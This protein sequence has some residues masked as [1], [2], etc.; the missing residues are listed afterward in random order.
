M[1]K[2]STRTVYERPREWDGCRL[3]VMRFWPRG[4]SRELIDV[5]LPEMGPLPDPLCSYRKGKIGWKAFA[6]E[7]LQ[8]LQ[9][10]EAREALRQ[11]KNLAEEG[12]VTVLCCCRDE[13]HCHRRLLID[14]LSDTRWNVPVT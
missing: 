1:S 9:R 13:D 11:V 6:R 3:L 8:G 4:V 10:P 7:Y 12:D 5:W 2:L 14:Y